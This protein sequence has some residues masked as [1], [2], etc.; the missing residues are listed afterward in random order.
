MTLTNS[1]TSMTQAKIL[2]SIAGRRIVFEA[3]TSDAA[4]QSEAEKEEEKVVDGDSDDGEKA[5]DED[6]PPSIKNRSQ[7]GLVRLSPG[8]RTVTGLR[9]GQKLT[10][11]PMNRQTGKSLTVPPTP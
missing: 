3:D 6:M 7:T 2:P 9:H 1:G 5:A 11:I 8:K 10:G 4:S